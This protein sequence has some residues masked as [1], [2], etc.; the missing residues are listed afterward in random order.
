M[1]YLGMAALINIS[2]SWDSCMMS[3]QP[4]CSVTA[5]SNP[6][7]SLWSQGARQGFIIA[8]ILSCCLYRC[9]TPPRWQRAVTGDS[10]PALKWW[11]SPQPWAKSKFSYNTIRELQYT[12]DNDIMT[13]SA[14][15]HQGILNTFPKAYWYRALKIKK[16]QVLH[17]PPPNQLST[18]PSIKLDNTRLRM[19][20][21]S[22]TLAALSP[23]MLTSALRPTMGCAVQVEQT[24]EPLSF[25]P[26]VAEPRHG[27]P[28]AGT[29]KPL[30]NTYKRFR[31]SAGRRDAPKSAFWRKT[32]CPE[33]LQQ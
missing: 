11:H 14:E 5:A 30:K 6:S 15:D 16:C 20:S 1:L 23:Q 21:T 31:G 22:Y 29:W 7:P 4:Q 26:A 32:A 2:A 24:P 28:T 10:S 3:C 9:H 12:Y 25:Q 19:L 33:S 13:H 8:P 17:Q 18:Q 27:L